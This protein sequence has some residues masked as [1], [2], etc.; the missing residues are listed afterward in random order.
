MITVSAIE[1]TYDVTND[2]VSI[3]LELTVSADVYGQYMQVEITSNGS[4]IL[5][6]DSNLVKQGVEILPVPPSFDEK[7]PVFIEM[8]PPFDDGHYQLV[9]IGNMDHTSWEDLLRSVRFSLGTEYV[10]VTGETRTITFTV[11]LYLPDD[12]S[13]AI[14]GEG[15]KTIKII[16]DEPPVYEPPVYEPPVE[17]PP[18]EVENS[19]TQVNP[20]SSNLTA[21]EIVE[22]L[23]LAGV[24]DVQADYWAAGSILIMINAGL[25]QPDENGNINPNAPMKVHEAV[26]VFAKVLGIASKTDTTEQAAEKMVQA[27]LMSSNSSLDHNMSRLAVA[28]MI[29]LILGITPK[30]ITDLESYPFTDYK[31]MSMEDAG[32]LAALYEFGIFKGY[33][34]KTFRPDGILSIGEIAILIDRMLGSGN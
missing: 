24:Q 25:I 33:E 13:Y 4:G 29:G 2:P 5:S 14:V 27:G 7:D 15:S 19:P 12:S 21:K 18:V 32:L 1:V 30:I 17:E 31:G 28:K 8:Q 11:S 23:E 9:I 34:D 10:P 16:G 6:F 3:D 20:P 22:G 26:S